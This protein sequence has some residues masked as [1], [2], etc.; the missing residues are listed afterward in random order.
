MITRR[1]FSALTLSTATLLGTGRNAHAA[2][3][4][5]MSTVLPDG[6][7]HTENAK[8]Y[9][10][11]VLAATSGEVKINVHSGGALGFKGPDH[12]R[13]VRDGL[14]GMADI[15]VSQQAGDEPIFAAE[16]PPFLVGNIDELR[17]L[18]RHLRPLF[19]AAAAKHNQ[20]ILYMVPW[21]SQY[22][23]SRVKA[24]SLDGLRNSK[25]RVSDKNVQD[26]CAAVGITP[27]LI[28][29]VETI[30]AL[31]SGAI[32]GVMTSAVSGVDGRLWEFVKYAY[33]TNHTWISQMVNINLDIWKKLSPTH[34]DAMTQAAKRLEPEFWARTNTVDGDSL[35]K[36]K[37]MGMEVLPVSQDMNNE[38]RRRTSGL[39]QAFEKSVPA[40]KPALTAYLAELK[41]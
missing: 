12:L 18:H 1:Q 34:Q 27:V 25:V 33:P 30:P 24:D 5:D 16:T 15:H 35:A 23:F 26:L 41:R 6:S 32:S 9:A 21:P 39:L 3:A 7:F 22:L 28:P 4:I 38:M 20:K 36:L 31:A 11:E 14:A 10:A 17:I 8:R 29:W 40:S 37:S 19:D 2:T 13:A